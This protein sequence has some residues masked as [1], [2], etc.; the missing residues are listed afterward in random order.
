[1]KSQFKYL[2]ILGGGVLNFLRAVFQG[3]VL[4]FQGAILN[5]GGVAGRISPQV[6]DAWS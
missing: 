1:M 6:L 3:A 5:L 2:I 4:N